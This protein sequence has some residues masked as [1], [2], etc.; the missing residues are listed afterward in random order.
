LKAVPSTGGGTP[1]KALTQR[2]ESLEEE[3]LVMK[4]KEEDTA[5]E[6]DFYFGKLREIE[7]LCQ[8]E[9]VKTKWDIMQARC[10]TVPLGRR[11]C[12]G[13]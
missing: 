13:T 8:A 6:R 2:I 7:L 3:L 11:S 1:D 4:Q 5:G 9:G 10:S 12:R